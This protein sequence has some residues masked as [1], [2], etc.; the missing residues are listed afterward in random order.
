MP[1]ELHM[2]KLRLNKH[3][4]LTTLEYRMPFTQHWERS[5]IKSRFFQCRIKCEAREQSSKWSTLGK[6]CSWKTVYIKLTALSP[7]RQAH[8][9][10]LVLA[11]CGSLAVTMA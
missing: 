6:R 1:I 9:L 4:G 11:Y 8:F 10:K 2:K 7:Y 5:T 3:D